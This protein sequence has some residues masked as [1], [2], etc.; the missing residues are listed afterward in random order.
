M[1]GRLRGMVGP[2]TTVETTDCMNV[3][4]RP[5]TVAFRAEGKAAYIF[6]GVD[7]EKQGEDLAAFAR[8][9]AQA[10][11]GIIED[12]R[13]CGDLRFCLIGRIPA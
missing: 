5:V 11:G 6:A 2:G 12:A 3:C 9:Y 8:L 10:E 1:A 13:P 7:P 4:G